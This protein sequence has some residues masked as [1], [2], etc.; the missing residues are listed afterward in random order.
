VDADVQGRA[1]ELSTTAITR[2]QVRVI[3]DRLSVILDGLRWTDV[4]VDADI[5]GRASGL[6]DTAITRFQVRV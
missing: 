5:Q 6:S 2:F 3:L 4:I 1:S